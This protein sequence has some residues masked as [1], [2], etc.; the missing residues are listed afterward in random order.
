M[1][2]SRAYSPYLDL[3]FNPYIALSFST[4]VQNSINR[5]QSIDSAIYEFNFNNVK[6]DFNPD[7]IMRNHDVYLIDKK[8]RIS[9]YVRGTLLCKCK[10]SIFDVEVIIFNQQLNDRMKYQKGSFL[11]INKCVIA[12]GI[13]ML[14]ITMGDVI[15]YRIPAINKEKIYSK[16]IKEYNYYSCEKL[17]NPY[18]YFSNAPID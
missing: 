16:I 7:D 18:E 6:Y 11:Y 4:C 14:P 8:L 5:Y 13:M 9:S 15:K 10:Y 1:Q 3:T 12:N 17:M 2:H